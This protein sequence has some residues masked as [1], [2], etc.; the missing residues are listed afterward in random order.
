MMRNISLAITGVLI[1]MLTACSSDEGPMGENG[2]KD[3]FDREAMLVNWADNIILPR[4]ENYNQKVGILSRAV[5]IFSKEISQAHLE[6]LRMA[7]L[8]A[9]MA[10][11]P[12]ASFE[13]GKAEELRLRNF[14]NVYP[15]DV[16]NIEENITEGTYNL[17]L[18]SKFD[19]QGF[20]ALDY[21]LFGLADSDERLL[22]KF[23]EEDSDN[24]YTRYLVDIT[25]RL[26][27]LTQQVL[28]DWKGGYRDVFIGNNGTSGTSSVNKIAN[29]FLFY[30]EKALRANKVGIPA[31]QFSSGPRSEFAEAFYN[32]ATSKALLL[33]SLDAVQSFFNGEHH[34]GTGFGPGFGSYLDVLSTS[35]DG[36]QLSKRI[37]DQFDRARSEADLLNPDLA[38]QVGEDNT[39]MLKTFDE[40][41][42]NVV[43]MKVDMFQALNI[44]V[45]FVDAD[46]D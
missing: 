18:S 7:W 13:I 3:D 36:E 29:D 5:G 1:I 11:Q 22:A 33:A 39:K 21:L 2:A 28:D 20:P 25:A 8:E 23:S 6:S 14:T 34:G 30:Y 43:L 17:S 4:Y 42:K 40:L 9:Y 32:G 45:D 44:R 15:A 46:G 26:Q 16:E 10:W 37:N 24:G 35:K 27:S 41:Q 38:T 31:G 19:E 12:V